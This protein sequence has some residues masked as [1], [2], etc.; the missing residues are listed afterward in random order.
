M[1]AIRR[2]S[3]GAFTAGQRAFI[4][5]Q[6]VA[7]LATV[8]AH[9]R[10]H[11]VPICFALSGGGLYSVIDEKPKHAAPTRLKRLRNIEANPHVCVLFDRYDEDWSRLR[12][13]QVRGTARV[14]TEGRRYEQALEALRTR[15]PQYQSMPLRGRPVIE[16]RPERV[17]GWGS[18]A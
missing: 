9:G 4:A 15:Y 18:S 3:R 14:L 10:P 6:R 12:W 1:A 16:V 13:L 17:V 8:D 7:R 11:V 2:N 5:Q